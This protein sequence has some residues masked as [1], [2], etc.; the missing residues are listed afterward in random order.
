M[1]NWTRFLESHHIDYVTSGPNTARGNI[2]IKCQWCDDPSEHLGISLE[3]KGWSCWRCKH[4]GK[5]PIGLIQKLIHVDYEEAA[6]IAGVSTTITVSDATFKTYISSMMTKETK[7][8]EQRKLEFPKNIKLLFEPGHAPAIQSRTWQEALG[9]RP[10]YFDR[11]LR[12]MRNYS[13]VE[14]ADVADMYQL[15]YALTG[16]YRYRL[17]FPIYDKDYHLLTWTG[18]TIGNNTIRYKTLSPDAD[19]AKEEGLPQALAS[20][21]DCLWNF[22]KLTN[23]KFETLILVEGPFDA[24]RLDYYGREHNVRSTCLFGQSVS[25]SQIS[26]VES[27][28]HNF[29]KLH[30]TLDHNSEGFAMKIAGKLAHLDC[31]MKRLP[32]DVK[33]DPA[34]MSKEQIEEWI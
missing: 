21:T 3:G 31:Q 17:V 24:L 1:F 34:D 22:N 26:L 15:R 6:R 12:A 32:E 9:W 5:S 10:Y 14:S 16:P 29:N 2:S 11:Y 19:K 4:G 33:K 25:D 30:V 18:R 20:I 8:N 28:R 13:I 23:T 7:V 27:I